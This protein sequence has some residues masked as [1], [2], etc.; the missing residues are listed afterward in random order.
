MLTTVYPP[1]R[2]L[3][4]VV[5]KLSVVEIPKKQASSSIRQF[6]GVNC[7]VPLKAEPETINKF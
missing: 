5:G 4:V 6:C 3:A 7:V 1:V 2:G